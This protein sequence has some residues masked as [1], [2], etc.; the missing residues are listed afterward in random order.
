MYTDDIRILHDLTR[1]KHFGP[2]DIGLLFVPRIVGGQILVTARENH[3]SI[4]DDIAG[5]RQM[6][7]I[8]DHR[9]ETVSRLAPLHG[10][11]G[12]G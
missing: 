12:G 6:Q 2:Q 10:H 8:G 11:H 1:P 9:E 3:F 4:L 7:R 5:H